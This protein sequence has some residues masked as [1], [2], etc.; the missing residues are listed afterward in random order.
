MIDK[1]TLIAESGSSKTDWRLLGP[2]GEIAQAKTVGFNPYY[3][4][5]ENIRITLIEE[6]LPQLSK[7]PEV[8]FFYGA[9]CSNENNKVLV[10]KAIQSV[11]PDA[12]VEV[13]HDLLAAAR[14]LCGHEPGIACI[15]GTGSNSC[16]YDGKNIVANIPSLGFMLGDEGS[17]GFL[18]KRL[19]ID[20][21]SGDLPGHLIEQFNH[22]YKVS[23][24]EILDNVYK[25]PFPNRY[26]ASFSKFL[27]HHLRDP[28]VFDLVL[29]SFKL[30]LK[31]TVYK[32]SNYKNY[33]THFTG[34]IAFY[35]NSIL[36]TACEEYGIVMGKVI[37]GPIA[38][39]TLFHSEA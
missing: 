34:S 39:L 1:P 38:G 30:F 16:L 31:K 14:A 6:L 35:F 29:S 23:K 9:G 36:R 32:Y 20:Y 26:L 3:Q 21:L 12:I 10:R 15:L 37:E 22:R 18:G 4:T 7:N 33:T 24:E 5:E 25:K 2:S 11:F 27:F 8:V 28:Y 19:I 13:E 17:G